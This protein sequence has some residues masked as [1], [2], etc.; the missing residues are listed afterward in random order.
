VRLTL[1]TGIR[2]YLK[3]VALMLLVGA[4]LSTVI[5]HLVPVKAGLTQEL[6]IG[7]WIGL[8]NLVW[9]PLAP[10]R[11]I[12]DSS[13]RG[14]LTNI[15]FIVQSVSITGAALWF[16]HGGWGLPGQFLAVLLG[17]LVFNGIMSWQG[18]RQY[19]D[20][21][22]RFN[23]IQHESAVGIQQQIR[24]LK[25]PT[26]LLNLSGQ[27]GLLTDNIIISYFLGPAAVVPFF[28]T[29]RLP[30]LA[31]AQAQGI[32][33]ATWA[34]LADLYAK[35]EL[36]QFNR[37]LIDLTKF[38]TIF[39]LTLLIPISVY[40]LYFVTLWVGIERF[41]GIEITLLATVNGL[42]QAILSLWGWCFSGTGKA[43]KIVRLS[44]TGASVNLIISLI[45]TYFLGMIGPLVGTL[46]AFM[47]VYLWWMPRQLHQV[48]GTSRQQLFKAFLHPL[49]LGIP[50]A[51]ALHSLTQHHRPD[52]WFG[53]VTEMGLAAVIFLGL[54]WT[55]LLSSAERQYW[56]DR[57]QHIQHT[58]F[59]TSRKQPEG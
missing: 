31:Q 56:R 41:G 27:V 14:Y 5:T 59:K 30:T 48:F 43:T 17:G 37:R 7:Y 42:I 11:L 39:G 50:Y 9:L 15:L 38:V 2:A 26:L 12:L 16:A 36:E 46:T 40:N 33:N 21:F 29:Q 44:I 4:G 45:A 25:I 54:V 19:P 49:G 57:L 1:T 28:M 3:V 34:A 10:F 13:Q 8:F 18:I 22:L 52:R 20:V 6:A 23:R 47:T 51:I 53:L 24:Q 32:G 35:G 58:L 55:F